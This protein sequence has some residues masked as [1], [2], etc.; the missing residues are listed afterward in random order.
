LLDQ[1]LDWLAAL[2]TAGQYSVLIALSSLENIFPPVPAD[3]AV[4][5]GAFLAQRGETQ[6]LTIG[7]ACWAANTVSA[8][9]MYVF[10]RRHGER[11]FRDGWPRRLLPPEAMTAIR[12]IYE[13][14][15]VV[16]IFISRFLPG[17]RAGV[18]PFAG[19]VGLSPLR[20]LLP[21]ALASAIWYALIVAAGTMLGLNWEAVKSL[22]L[23]TN[24]VLGLISIALLVVVVWLLLRR[25]RKR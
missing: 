17:F 19:V 2:P 16:G 6:A 12:R 10:A 9:G 1:F 24:R 11:F 23:R 4:G 25:R 3:V 15:G 7:L 22:L 5:L 20:A 18:T 8:A 14:Y 13:R 21:A